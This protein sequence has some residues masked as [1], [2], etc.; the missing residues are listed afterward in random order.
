[1]VP[2]YQSI[3]KE[4]LCVSPLCAYNLVFGKTDKNDII[5]IKLL[6][7][8]RNRDQTIAGCLTFGIDT[9]ID[10]LQGIDKISD[11]IR[12]QFQQPE[13]AAKLV[14]GRLKNK[15]EILQWL[16]GSDSLID[17]LSKLNETARGCAQHISGAD[18]LVAAAPVKRSYKKKK[19]H[20]SAEA[21][22]K[23]PCIDESTIH[24]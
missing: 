18:K 6:S 19:V 16:A 14:T 2:K 15:P 5:I 9:F 24:E 3:A 1:M 8:T 4:K 22:S 20:E 12:T 21:T 7:K 10:I 17:Y 13:I 23:R 11:K